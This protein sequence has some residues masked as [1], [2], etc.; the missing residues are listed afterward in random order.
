M[1]RGADH[2]R[3]TMNDHPC[4]DLRFTDCRSI[5]LLFVN[6]AESSAATL[7]GFSPTGYELFQVIA[8]SIESLLEWI[9]LRELPTS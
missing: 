3:E 1:N 7:G 5:E 4:S 6:T 2:R 8:F 9:D